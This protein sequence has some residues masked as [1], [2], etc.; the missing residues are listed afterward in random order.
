MT[1][2]QTCALPI[3]GLPVRD[4]DNKQFIGAVNA[5]VD[6]SAISSI[7]N[8]QS[9]SAWPRILLVKDDGT[10]IAARQGTY[11]PKVKSR[12]FAALRDQ[13]GTLGVQQNGY[14]VANFG[15]GGSQLIGFADTGLKQD[16]ENLGWVVLVCQD[17]RQAFGAMH[18]VERMIALVSGI[19]LFMVSLLVAYFAMHRKQP[20]TDIGD[21]AHEPLTNAYAAKDGTESDE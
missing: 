18:L 13:E 16:Y 11:S 8:A 19:G 21:V 6:V 4:D 3:F 12:E 15:A 9:G 17:T 1:G 14:L 20:F 5:L 2:V 7:A 10:V